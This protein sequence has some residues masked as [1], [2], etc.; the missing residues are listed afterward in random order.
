[1]VVVVMVVLA[2]C[3]SVVAAMVGVGCIRRCRR[4]IGWVGRRRW[5]RGRRGRL[6]VV[7]VAGVLVVVRGW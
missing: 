5:G 7:L 4:L 1:M 2:G 6:W 3:C